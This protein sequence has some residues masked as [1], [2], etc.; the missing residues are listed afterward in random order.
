[1]Q[2]LP[3]LL[4]VTFYLPYPPPRIAPPSLPHHPIG[5]PHTPTRTKIADIHIISHQM[6]GYTITCT[7]TPQVILLLLLLLIHPP[8]IIM[9]NLPPAT[10]ICLAT[11]GVTI[12]SLRH[13]CGRTRRHHIILIGVRR[14]L[15]MSIPSIVRH[16]SRTYRGLLFSVLSRR[17]RL[18][19]L[20]FIDFNKNLC[21]EY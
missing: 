3:P 8:A 6:A 15:H 1:M 9:G 4:I 20:E 18:M 16:R 14:G 19:D 7:P 10:P 5:H 2:V 21:I 17:R 13:L 11:I 12:T